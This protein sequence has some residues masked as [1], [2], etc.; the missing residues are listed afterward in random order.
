MLKLNVV[1]RTQEENKILRGCLSD[2]SSGEGLKDKDWGCITQS[3]QYNYY[4]NNHP[5]LTN[6]YLNGVDVGD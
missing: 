3:C 2:T 1:V 4:M 6:C 5:L